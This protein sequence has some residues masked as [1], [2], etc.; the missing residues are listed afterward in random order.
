M[1]GFKETFTKEE[2]G[3]KNLDYDDSAFFYFA[4]VL[5]I[6]ILIPVTYTFIKNKVFG[7]KTK[8]TPSLSNL[9][10]GSVHC[11]CSFCAEKRVNHKDLVSEKKFGL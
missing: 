3:E 10:P 9:S 6:L 7:F 1:S 8:D 11:P 5:Q 4:A 2:S